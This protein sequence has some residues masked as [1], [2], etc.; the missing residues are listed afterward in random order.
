MGRVTQTRANT[1]S[2]QKATSH[3]KGA[4]WGRSLNKF[5]IDNASSNNNNSNPSDVQT[6]L[7]L[8]T[9]L[10]H[11]LGHF[12]SSQSSVSPVQLKA[13]Y[14]APIQRQGYGYEDEEQMMSVWHEDSAVGMTSPYAPMSITT[15][16]AVSNPKSHKQLKQPTNKK[17]DSDNEL[18]PEWLHTGLDIVGLI[19]GVGEIADGANAFLYGAQ[20][21]HTEAA[22]SAAA[23]IPGLGWGATG[24]KL[25]AKGAKSLAK[26]SG[27][28]IAET[29]LKK[30]EKSSATYLSTA[31]PDVY[32]HDLFRSKTKGPRH[33][34]KSRGYDR[35]N[36]SHQE[37]LDRARRY[38]GRPDKVPDKDALDLGHTGAPYSRL[39]P[40]QETTLRAQPRGENRS[41]GATEEKSMR[42]KLIELSRKLGLDPH[43]PKNPYYV[44]P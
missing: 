26:S 35:R 8:A 3:K 38:W 4:E 24:G 25:A 29:G 40:G 6:Q 19:P 41:I 14:T 11:Q 30:S 13:D 15:P 5:S 34:S 31:K 37:V 39:R 7:H 9:N 10:G 16:A 18:V 17:K 43:D 21:R 20:G 32:T 33:G 27:K 36:K 22:L 28:E 12:Q 23:M 42:H 44:R 1:P 2:I